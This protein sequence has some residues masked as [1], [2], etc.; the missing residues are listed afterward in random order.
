MAL[1]V[2]DGPFFSIYPHAD[3]LFSLT[4]VKHTHIGRFPNRKS[5]EDSINKLGRSDLRRIQKHMES[6]ALRY[7]PDFKS[8]F[9]LA[10]HFC[11]IKTKI[12]SAC[13]DRLAEFHRDDR[14]LDVMSGKIDSIF[15]LTDQID[16]VL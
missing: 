3:G 12:R 9:R 6:Q 7:Y 10:D 15:E 1:T 16:G 14:L 11:S 5:A 4:S 13:D 2:V 8:R